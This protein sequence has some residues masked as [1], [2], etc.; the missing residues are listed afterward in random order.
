MCEIAS[1]Y[2]GIKVAVEESKIIYDSKSI[3][4][5]LIKKSRREGHWDSLSKTIRWK[6]LFMK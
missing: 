2:N 5:H 6:Y 3:R 4:L 1:Q